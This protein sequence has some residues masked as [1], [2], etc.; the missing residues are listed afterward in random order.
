MEQF[1][2]FVKDPK[3]ESK[4]GI[5][6][7]VSVKQASS[8]LHERGLVVIKLIPKKKRL[9]P[10]DYLSNL[11]PVN[12][13]ELAS[14]TRQLAT[15]VSSG[16]SLVDSLLLLERQQTN[17]RL[18]LALSDIIRDI[19]GGGNLG[20][21][22]TRQ[23][24]V[25]SS[26]YV[27][28]IKAGESSGTLD[29]I[30]NKLAESLEKNREFHSKVVS[31]MI[32]PTILVGVTVLVISVVSIYVLPKL[33]DLFALSTVSLPLPTLIL[34]SVSDLINKLWVLILIILGVSVLL[35]V[36][37]SR[38]PYIREYLDRVILQI[39]YVGE[40]N[41]N[42]SL[43]QV[44]RTL[45]LLV[46]GGV[47]IIEGLKTSAQVASN[48]Y[49]KSAVLEAAR[50]VEKGMP[51][52]VPI[53]RNP[54]FPPVVGQMISVGE[55]TGKLEDVLNKIAEYFEIEAEHKVRNFTAALEPMII[56]FLAVGILFVLVSVIIP[57]YRLSTSFS[58]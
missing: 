19:Q 52:S 30:L 38:T 2:Y 43:A 6:E 8:L 4:T 37:F 25:F 23:R 16:L 48:S 13:G 36:R 44:S 50:D 28:M 27:S 9:N 5:I 34:I 53:S 57:L 29:V 32:Y 12:L 14:F 10:L 18:K 55:E 42:F 58:A 11:R 33:K 24:G 26:T 20:N 1:H 31:A 41:R 46:G 15:M 21:A 39:P 56:V 7:A 3:G 35:F 45:A 49:H 47:P 22:M 17:P 54:L 40:I 51:L